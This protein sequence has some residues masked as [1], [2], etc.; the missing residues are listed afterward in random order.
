LLESPRRQ[1]EAERVGAAADGVHRSDDGDGDFARHAEI[2]RVNRLVG[3][4][5]AS[6]ALRESRLV[7]EGTRP[8]M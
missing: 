1:F 7:D 2:R 8:V 4:G 3:L 5:S 6:T